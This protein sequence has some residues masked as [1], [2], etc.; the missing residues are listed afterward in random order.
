MT[1]KSASSAI[2]NPAGRK[3]TDARPR[4]VC[5]AAELEL[6][7]LGIGCWAFGG[8]EY[9]GRQSQD[10]VD[11]IVRQA[12]D[13]GCNFFDTAEAYNAGASETSL[14]L[15]LRGIPRDQVIVCTKISPNHTAPA[16][17]VEHCE[18]SLRRLQTDYIDLYM[19]HWPI[20]GHSI[21]HFVTESIPTPSASAA[22]EALGRLRRAGKHQGGRDAARSGGEGR[23]QPTHPAAARGPRPQFRLLRAPGQRPDKIVPEIPERRP[24]LQPEGNR[25]ESDGIYGAEFTKRVVALG[26]ED[27][28]I[29]PRAPWQNP[30]V[31]RL[32]GTLRRECLD[33][34]IIIDERHLQTVLENY[35]EYY[36]HSRPH[37]SL[38][39]DSPVT[40]PVLTPEQGR[41]VEFPQVGGL[42]HL[43]TR[44]AA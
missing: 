12:V 41:V 10:E 21:Q 37:R 38:A 36:H 7:L 9:W 40:R 43:Y 22:F 4:R 11:Q 13:G 8:G 32:I 23:A 35:F 42:H 18:A 33:R 16:T 3:P 14:G 44:Q 25:V 28:P 30:Y 19:V 2:V 1:I 20:T 39:Q 34:V 27:K 17:L 5:G 26:I 15:A 29:A 24:P 31:E 6:P